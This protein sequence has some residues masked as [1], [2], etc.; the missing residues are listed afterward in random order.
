MIVGAATGAGKVKTLVR[1]Q[2]PPHRDDRWSLNPVGL[3][4]SQILFQFPPHRDDRWSRCERDAAL[5]V[6][7]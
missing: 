6:L 3:A 2:F 5:L 4:T 1:F 7:N